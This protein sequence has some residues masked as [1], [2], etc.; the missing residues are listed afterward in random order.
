VVP[1]ERT[2]ANLTIEMLARPDSLA[3]GA[4]RAWLTGFDR[5]T[6]GAMFREAGLPIVPD[7]RPAQGFFERSDNIVFARRGVPAHTLSSFEQHADYH[8]PSDDVAHADPAHL[9]QVITATVRAVRLLA[10]GPAPTWAPGGRP[11]EQTPRR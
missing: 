4:G 10:D 3:G 11:S 7:P 6:M 2:V 5:S 9:A 8:Q 1:L